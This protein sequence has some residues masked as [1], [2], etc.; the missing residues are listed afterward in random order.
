MKKAVYIA[1]AALALLAVFAAVEASRWPPSEDADD[2]ALAE[3][4]KYYKKHQ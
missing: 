3:I 2:I 1:L 4:E